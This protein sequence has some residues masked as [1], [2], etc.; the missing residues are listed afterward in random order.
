MFNRRKPTPSTGVSGSIIGGH[1][2]QF[3]VVGGNVTI[4][5]GSLDYRVEFVTPSSAET[6]Q[7][8]LSDQPSYL[9]DPRHQVVPYRP[10]AAEEARL[11]DWLEDRGKRVSVLMLTGPAGQGKTRLASHVASVLHQEGWAIA[12]AVPRG[13]HRVDGGDVNANALN[14][15]QPLLVV[16]DYAE[17][18]RLNVLVR[19]VES[20]PRDFKSRRVRVL[21]LSRQGELVWGTIAAELAQIEVDRRQ[22]QQQPSVIDLA[23]PIMLGEFTT[24]RA[25]AFAEAVAAFTR[26]MAKPDRPRP[27]PPP[28]LFDAAYASPLILHMAALAAVYGI[29]TGDSVPGDRD[30]QALSRYLLQHERRYWNATSTA[31]MGTSTASAIVIEE[32]V[33]WATLFGPVLGH[34]AATGL[35]Q[36]VGLADGPA[37]AGRLL[38]VH[39]RL[40]PAARDKLTGDDSGHQFKVATL[41]PLQPD[42]LGEDFVGNYLA[43]YPHPIEKIVS[44][45]GAED[46]APDEAKTLDLRRCMI[47]LAA[48]ASRHQAATK[49]ICTL[50]GRWPAL[51]AHGGATVVQFV[52]DHAP[53]DLADTVSTAL[54]MHE[55]ELGP[56]LPK[57]DADLLGPAADLTH[58]AVNELP[59]DAPPGLR[60]DR[61][62]HLGNRLAHLGRCDEASTAI[63]K[64]VG[65]YR[66]LANGNP[67]YQPYLAVAMSS[68]CNVTILKSMTRHVLLADEEI[69][70]V[71]LWPDG[72]ALTTSL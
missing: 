63:S 47:V 24:E 58:R 18:W 71:R 72:L 55:A 19:L 60:A 41:S 29:T 4:L 59:A 49:T 68:L 30:P 9:L 36:H 33:W 10:R 53:S 14:G 20:V 54:P 67:A 26:Q 45:I 61:I 13:A 16:V 64:A 69:S 3:G 15:D 32:V 27:S 48:A 23:K 38:E 17:R 8:P 11:R 37:E 70:R 57:Y 42:R 34:G 35:L 25:E 66:R 50:L 12:Q 31:P 51:A 43:T 65:I 5:L 6:P 2:I 1:N 21:M 39:E 52:A 46:N 40:Y 22:K 44:L 62:L 7:P 56:A 28:N